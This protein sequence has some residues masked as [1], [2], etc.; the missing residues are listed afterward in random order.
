MKRI[1][2]G[3]IPYRSVYTVHRC[4]LYEIEFSFHICCELATTDGLIERIV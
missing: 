1:L 2:S 3:L 4:R